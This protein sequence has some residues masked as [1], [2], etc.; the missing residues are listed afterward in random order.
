MVA[1]SIG[2]PFAAG[3]R[4]SDFGDAPPGDLVK[5]SAPLSQI[6][7]DELVESQLS[8]GV[9]VET[10][11]LAALAGA[12]ARTIGDGI[13]P[14][15]VATQDGVYP[16]SLHCVT[17]YELCANEM[18]AA[19]H[20]ALAAARHNGAGDRQPGTDRGTEFL[21]SSLDT[22]LGTPSSLGYPIELQV[23]TEDGLLQLDWW[24]DTHRFNASTV[25]DLAEQFPLALIEVTS[26][27]VPPNYPSL[28]GIA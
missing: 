12:V 1:R 9:A 11:I 6:V 27:A 22:S 15:D 3:L 2:S 4:V 23:Y 5:L 16:V 7:T 13:V 20:G 25:E 19:V 8:L 26:E 17:H 10:L 28:R 18:L 14:I 21:F 24:Y